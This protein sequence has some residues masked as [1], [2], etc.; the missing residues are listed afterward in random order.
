MVESWIIYSTASLVIFGITN[1]L[2]KYISDKAPIAV[3]ATIISISS[4]IIPLGY[5]LY[6]GG[7]FQISNSTLIIAVAFGLLFSI[8]FIFLGYSLRSGFAS[9]VI[10]VVNLNTLVT[11]ALAVLILNE[12]LT[13]KIGLGI[14]FAIVS[15]YL[16]TS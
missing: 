6:G 9:K 2:F 7:K 13:P 5:F 10:P 1:F 11:V 12:K 3:L 8:S 16:L 4:V 15:L 14:G